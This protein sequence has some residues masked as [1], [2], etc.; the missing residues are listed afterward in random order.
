MRVRKDT[1]YIYPNLE[2]AIVRSRK[3]QADITKAI[4]I[5]AETWN[6]RLGG[7]SDWKLWEMLAVRDLLAP[8]MTLD[9]LFSRKEV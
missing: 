6:R 3:R 1:K 9:E 8:D 5:T 4:G 2:L 7:V